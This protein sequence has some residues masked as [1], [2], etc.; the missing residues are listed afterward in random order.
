MDAEE[1]KRKHAEAMRRWRAAH[2]E[3]KERQKAYWDTYY[4]KHRTAL[5]GRAREWYEQNAE[6]AKSR[7]SARY[8]RQKQLK[9]YATGERIANWKG[10]GAG[11]AALHKWVVRW[12]G[13]PS[14]CVRCG[15]SGEGRYEWANKDHSYRRV[16]DDWLRLCHRCHYIF[17]IEMGNRQP[18]D[19][20][21]G[22]EARRNKQ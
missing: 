13:K 22:V 8:H 17:D 1:K 19:P 4:S 21:R 11:Y 14:Q 15:K 18:I 10:D 7:E 3:H 16:L 6:R 2:P 12:K 5:Q 9:G 20:Q